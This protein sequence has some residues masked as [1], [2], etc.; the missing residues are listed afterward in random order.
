MFFWVHFSLST[1]AV[2]K[3]V[4]FPGCPSQLSVRFP[5]SPFQP[6]VV[7]GLWQIQMYPALVVN[8]FNRIPEGNFYFVSR[9]G[10]NR[11]ALSAVSVESVLFSWMWDVSHRLSCQRTQCWWC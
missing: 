4:L 11:R 6:G 1:Q 9:A 10:Q 7:P 3:K 8:I 5:Q 2:L